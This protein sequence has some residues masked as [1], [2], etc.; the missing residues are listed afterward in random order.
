MLAR[1]QLTPPAVSQRQSLFRRRC[2]FGV[3]L[4]GFLVA[5]HIIAQKGQEPFGQ[6]QRRFNHGAVAHALEHLQVIGPRNGDERPRH[7]I[8]GHNLVAVAPDQQGRQCQLAGL[9][10]AVPV[11][12]GDGNCGE[13]AGAMAWASSTNDSKKAAFAGMVVSKA[14]IDAA[15]A[16]L[17]SWR[18]SRICAS[19]ANA[20][21]GVVTPS[22]GVGL[23]SVSVLNTSWCASAKSMAMAHELE[24]ATKSNSSSPSAETKAHRS[25]AWEAICIAI[26][27]SVAAAAAAQIGRNGVDRIRQY[28]KKGQPPTAAA[29]APMHQQH[30][31]PIRITLRPITKSPCPVS[32]KGILITLS[33]FPL[34]LAP[35]AGSPPP[36]REE[37]E[38]E[39]GGSGPGLRSLDATDLLFLEDQAAL[40]DGAVCI[41]PAQFAALEESAALDASIGR[42]CADL[43]FIVLRAAEDMSVCVAAADA[44]AFLPAQP[45]DVAVFVD[46]ADHR[47]RRMV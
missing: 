44:V 5:A 24:C 43:A 19:S 7:P 32:I 27:R 15:R 33:P 18:S 3:P 13:G 9:G 46:V 22:M 47:F 14:G 1:G 12:E 2:A 37:D 40:Y 17:C 25:S 36:H 42:E 41:Q 21:A 4:G 8:A 11:A 20:S 30:G 31:Q 23:M 39:R 45:V 6:H 34:T 38:Q 29:M 26:P 35:S 16:W 28:V 10:Q